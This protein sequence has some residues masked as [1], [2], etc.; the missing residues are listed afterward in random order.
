MAKTY[1]EANRREGSAGDNLMVLLETRLDALVFRM[2]FARTIFAARQ[3]VAHGHFSVNGVRSFSPSR[4]VKV[5]DVIAVRER[6]KNHVQ[7]KEALENA[8]ALPEYVSVD[9]DKMEGKLVAT[10]LRAQIPVQLQEQL[11]VEYYSR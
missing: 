8:P 2:G 11:V 6:S 1:A 5:G 9:K 10:P 7:I 4:L 3:Y